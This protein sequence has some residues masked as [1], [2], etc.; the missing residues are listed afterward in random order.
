LTFRR[1]QPGKGLVVE[2]TAEFVTHAK[3]G[4]AL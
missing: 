1:E 2:Q 3:S 4:T